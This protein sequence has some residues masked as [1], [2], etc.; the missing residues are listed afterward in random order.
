[1]IKTIASFAIGILVGAAYASH[2]PATVAQAPAAVT[3]PFSDMHASIA[4]PAT[5][6]TPAPTF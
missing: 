1:M 6:E 4:H 3:L 2:S 5:L